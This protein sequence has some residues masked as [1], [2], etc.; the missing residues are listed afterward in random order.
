MTFLPPPL[1]AGD[2]VHVPVPA[3]PVKADC[4][5]EGL[6]RLRE[7]GWEVTSGGQGAKTIFYSAGTD[8]ERAAD[9]VAAL[10]DPGVRAV[11]P[12]RGGYGCARLLP[13]LDEAFAAGP[14]PGPKWLLGCSDITALLL[15][16]RQRW[17]WPV[18]HGPMPAGDISRGP[19]QC[20]LDY[21]FGLLEGGPVRE[22]PSPGPL[23][24]LQ[25]GG[26]VTAPL[27][28]GCLSL[29]C[30]T[31]GTP[32]EWETDGCLLFLEDSHVK[33]YQLDRM[34][35]QLRQAGKLDCCAGI[36]FGTMPGCFQHPDQGYTL[37]EALRH[38]L[39]GVAVPVLAGLPSGHCDGP[40]V[41]LVFGARHRLS[42]AR[43]Q[44]FRAPEETGPASPPNGTTH[45]G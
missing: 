12:A 23:A 40:S 39:A 27:T 1:R 36:V 38:A 7:R 14:P 25:D 19:G 3:S 4:L 43:A 28:G 9:L 29:L 31:L 13:A 34:I 30:A 16:A 22:T 8:A 45:D 26:E 37:H 24:V 2:R 5:A 11:W 42:P 17:G 41:P 44:L 35:T 33:P 10:A 32:Y 21:L 20:D 15:Y 18:V 6:R